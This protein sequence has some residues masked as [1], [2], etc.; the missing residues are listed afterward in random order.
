MAERRRFRFT[1]LFRNSTP[2]P[3]DRSVYN[4]GIQ[5]KDTSYLLTSPVMYHIAQQSVIV[6]TCTTQL[7]QEVFRRGYVWEEK[8]ALRCNTCGKEHKAPVKICGDCE[9]TDFSK[10]DPK[11][12][13]YAKD[14]LGGYVNKSEQMFIDVLKEMEDDLNIM[15][16]AYL[17]M[18]KEYYLDNDNNIKMHRIKEVYRGDPI[19]MHIYSDEKGERGTSGFTCLRHR[20]VISQNPTGTCETCNSKL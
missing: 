14:M 3:L 13:K 17:V 6:R 15:D 20:D 1:N 2:K 8:F 16:D 10:P 9:G 12:L 11:Q 7:K 5:E 19:G 4:I 18:V